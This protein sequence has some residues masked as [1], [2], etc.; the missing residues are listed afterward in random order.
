[1]VARR[2]LRP[3]GCLL[4]LN[5]FSLD[6]EDGYGNCMGME[7]FVHDF[8]IGLVCE[9]QGDYGGNDVVYM[10]WRKPPA[11]YNR[12]AELKN[13]NSSD[14][15]RF[16]WSPQWPEIDKHALKQE[17]EEFLEGNA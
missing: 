6:D 9:A 13:F 8:E 4:T 7:R 15:Q 12:M 17:E 2:L 1:M 16:M 14:R 3:N 10:I 5:K 11:G